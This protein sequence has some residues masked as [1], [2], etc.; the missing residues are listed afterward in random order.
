M[1]E[2]LLPYT[3][4]E[5][6]PADLEVNVDPWP[7]HLQWRTGSWE[8]VWQLQ[9]TE[10]TDFA[11]DVQQFLTTTTT[12]VNGQKVAFEMV[13]LKPGVE[14]KW[15]VRKVGVTDPQWTQPHTFVTDTKH[16]Q[17]LTPH[18]GARHAKYHPWAL[19]FSWKGV[20]G[21][22]HYE[23]EVAQASVA[24][25]A[26]LIFP[27][28][29]I[30]G[31]STQ[32]H[33]SVKAKLRW[34]ARAIPVVGSEYAGQWSEF[35]LETTM[36]RVYISSPSKD[37]P[38]YPWPVTLDWGPVT[39]AAIYKIELTRV[40]GMWDHESLERELEFN[41]PTTKTTLNLKPQYLAVDETH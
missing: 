36:P 14:Y 3:A 13:P 5:T 38:V 29:P 40:K 30:N 9:I 8:S 31:T 7:A 28:V 35:P 12:T 37:E 6:W 34:R 16:V 39:G 17:L 24:D 27:M 11:G 32:L 1:R 33:V 21:A 15:R 22:D 2:V 19:K 23:I 20:I 26:T 18:S 25:F 41:H 4:F 10:G